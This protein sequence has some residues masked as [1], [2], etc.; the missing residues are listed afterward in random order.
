MNKDEFLTIMNTNA[1]SLCPKITSLIDNLNNLECQ[2]GIVTETWLADG[3]S[4]RQDLQDLQGGA[5]Y[6]L[7]P[8]NRPRGARGVAHG[9]VAILGKYSKISMSRF[10]IHNPKNYE[11]LPVI[12]K[13]AGQYS[14][15]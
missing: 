10:K 5:G 12:C 7:L 9:G 2:V 11:I 14:R 1:R 6:T 3:A 13:I 4:L 15:C 8:L